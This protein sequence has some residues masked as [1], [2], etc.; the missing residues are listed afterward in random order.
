[1]LNA[2]ERLNNKAGQLFLFL[3]GMFH[4]L[5]QALGQLRHVEGVVLA[6]SSGKDPLHVLMLD[7]GVILVIIAVNVCQLA[8][9]GVQDRLWSARVPLLTA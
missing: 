7:L 1:M 3:Q 6:P 8:A 2:T 4:L 9:H 5:L